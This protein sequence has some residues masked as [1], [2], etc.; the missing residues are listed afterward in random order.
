MK[1]KVIDGIPIYYNKKLDTI[2]TNFQEMDNINSEI[3]SR[4]IP[5]GVYDTCIEITTKCNQ[6]CRNCFSF[7]DPRQRW[8]E[9][10]YDDI[11]QIIN[12]KQ[13]KR[14]RIGITGGEP[15]LHKDIYRVLNL[16]L[17]FQNLN[18]MISTNGYFNLTPEFLR[19]LYKGKWLVSVSLHG[20]KNTHN[21]Y[22]N[23]N[24][25]DTVVQNI[26]KL[27]TNNITIHIYTVINRF[28]TAE[29]I[30]YIMSLKNKYNISYIRFIV[31]RDTGRV[32]LNYNKSIIQYIQKRIKNI[33][34]VGIKNGYSHTE[35]IDVNLESKILG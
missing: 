34:E 27:S 8:K 25:F 4:T 19:M 5:E 3:Y 16:P 10:S 14:I 33:E 2:S 12:E 21:L 22:T 11:K 29:D 7:S 23:A 35:L 1:R 32:D 20:N 9:M 30:E 6:Y 28:M 13:S 31:P 18:F 17:E 15:F 26:E 24:S